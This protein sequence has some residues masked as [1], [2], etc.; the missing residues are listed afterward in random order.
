VSQD[1][2]GDP[3]T[4]RQICS[5]GTGIGG[6]HDSS[7]ANE[8]KLAEERLSFVLDAAEV[9]TWDWDLETGRL[10][11][12]PRCLELYGF[13]PGSS[14]TYEIF[15]RAVHPLDR[16]QIDAA[17][18]DALARRAGYDVEMRVVW[19]DSSVHWI[20]SKGRAYFDE[21]AR[22]VRMAGIALDISKRKEAEQNLRQ[23]EERF[24]KAFLNSPVAQALTQLETGRFI[25]VNEAWEQL[26]GYSREEVIGRMR[27]DLN[28]WASSEDAAKFVS[29]LTRNGSILH[30]ERLF[31]RKSG[32]TFIG[33]IS[34][35]LLTVGND[36]VALSTII[37]LTEQKRS[38]GERERLSEQLQLALDAARMGW[39]RY[40]ALTQTTTW[41]ERFREIFSVSG[42]T[43]SAEDIP[44]HVHPDDR[45]TV[46]NK[47]Q[48]AMDPGNPVPYEAEYRVLRNDGSTT[49]VLAYGKTRFDGE[50]AAAHPIEMVG[51]VQD[52]TERKRAE[53]AL[54]RSE[55][56]A[57]LGRMAATIAHEI[58]NPLSAVTNLIYLAQNQAGLPASAIELLESAQQ[59]LRRVAHITSQSLGF[60]RDSS[61][62]A[63]ISLASI[64]ESA[65]SL[66][67]NKVDTKRA[68]IRR[69]WSDDIFIPCVA[70]ELRQVATNL[71]GN[72]L[73][74]IGTEGTILIR[75]RQHGNSS[76]HVAIADDGGGILPKDRKHLFEPLFSTKAGVG[77]GL[78]LW[79]SRQIIEKHR[80]TIRVRSA[81][82]GT[83][84][85]TTLLIRLPVLDR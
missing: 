27:R 63:M 81:A 80:G 55:K 83:R 8:L 52:V 74:A 58:N 4:P 3:P 7:L 73:D 34:S 12:S 25:D 13:T 23:I 38:Q 48:A 20:S 49:W 39:W 9:G 37:D 46:L 31:L 14:V 44:A 76:V 45:A 10:A 18:R 30:A 36:A 1:S 68:N 62:P 85:G 67:R 70:N 64:F 51:T 78:G 19:P 28:I 82:N 43:S 56:L 40:D 5:P 66:L 42:L 32:E 50:G 29:I 75:I 24:S 61:G 71:I 77:T 35:Q 11:W 6:T 21:S 2:N 60:F 59:E 65:L 69:D 33:E 54:L 57:S 72:A 15:L 79:V 26:T 47:F 22:P 16:A 84:R 53:E 41:D 17:V